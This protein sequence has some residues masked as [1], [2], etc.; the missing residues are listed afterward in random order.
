VELAHLEAAWAARYWKRAREY[1]F[2]RLTGQRMIKQQVVMFIALALQM[3]RADRDGQR[4]LRGVPARADGLPNL[5]LKDAE[6]VR[7]KKSSCACRPIGRGSAADGCRG[8][9]YRRRTRPCMGRYRHADGA[10]QPERFGAG[11]PPGQDRIS[12]LRHVVRQFSAP[13]SRWRSPEAR[14]AY[15][16]PR[17]LRRPSSRE[18]TPT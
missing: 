14:A 9:T 3:R 18:C 13:R 8:R 1:R 5:V 10:L 6:K 17:D 12:Q 15:Y 2:V 16:I 11:T 7:Y 4:A